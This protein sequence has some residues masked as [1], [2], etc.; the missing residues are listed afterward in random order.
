MNNNNCF[1]KI[2]IRLSDTNKLYTELKNFEYRHTEVPQ[3]IYEAARTFKRCEV[4]IDYFENEPIKDLMLKYKLEAK[5]FLVESNHFYNWHRDTFS[6]N[7]FNMLLHGD[8]NY[9]TLFSHKT[10]PSEKLILTDFIYKPMTRLIYEP[11]YFYLLNS[12]IPHMV[13]NYGEVNRYILTLASYEN[14]AL[15]AWY[16]ENANYSKYDEMV[17]ELKEINLI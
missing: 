10:L 3:K 7:A 13:V 17:K 15:G 1:E 11:G 12:Q 6:Y 16:G 9:L 8:D 4:P 5:I 14:K 2:N